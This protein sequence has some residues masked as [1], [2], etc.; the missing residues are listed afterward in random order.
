MG[1][2]TVFGAGMAAGAL[3]F[4]ILQP[5][6]FAPEIQAV[7]S[8]EDGEEIPLLLDG[9]KSSIDIEIY[10]FTSRDVVEALE[11]AKARGVMVRIIIERNVI[12]DDNDAI[13]QE[14]ASKGFRIRYASSAY[15]LTHAKFIIVDGK[16]VLVG[17]HN[18]SNS[19]LYK[20]RE[21]SVIIRDAKAV[22]EFMDVF[23]TDWALAS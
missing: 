18:L 14:L 8:P 1:K 13:F 11:R 6:L 19:A 10:V 23:A 3:L 9:A 7:F 16:A 12:S 22:G 2:I 15:K 5:A 4:F 21:A 17:S 20:N